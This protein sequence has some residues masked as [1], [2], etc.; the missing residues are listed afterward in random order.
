LLPSWGLLLPPLA[1]LLQEGQL[2]QQE[3]DSKVQPQALPLC[4]RH[5]WWDW[6]DW[7]MVRQQQ[8]EREWVQEARVSPL[9]LLLLLVLSWRGPPR[10]Q[11][12]ACELHHVRERLWKSPSPSPSPS[13]SL[14]LE[15]G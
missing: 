15:Q 9:G 7:K 4:R 8:R 13:L 1:L 5:A 10:R 11:H 12:R 6:W 14:L 2:Q 3:L